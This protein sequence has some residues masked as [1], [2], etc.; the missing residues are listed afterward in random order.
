M[1][2]LNR[3]PLNLKEVAIHSGEIIIMGRGGNQALAEYSQPRSSGDFQYFVGTETP[4][5][6]EESERLVADLLERFKIPWAYEPHT[7]ALEIDEDG[8]IRNAFRPDFY[9][10]EQDIYIE[11]TVMRSEN[12]NRKNRKIRLAEDRYGITVKRCYS[13]QLRWLANRYGFNSEIYSKPS[14]LT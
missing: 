12:R 9:L 7:F 1:R 5:F 14:P 3:A 8:S 11:V 13:R 6:A 4:L 10:P 2:S